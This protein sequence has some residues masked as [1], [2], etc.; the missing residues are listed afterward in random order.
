MV[1]ALNASALHASFPRLDPYPLVLPWTNILV[2]VLVV[3]LVAALAAA[4]LTRSK[5]PLV[6]RLA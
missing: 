1:R 2:T 6:R 3:P 4:L 5:L